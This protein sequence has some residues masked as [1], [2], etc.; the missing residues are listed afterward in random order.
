[1]SEL[2]KTI[3]ERIRARHKEISKR[4]APKMYLYIKISPKGLFY[5]GV[6]KDRKYKDKNIYTYRGSGKY[7]KLH[8]KSHNVTTKDIETII[9]HESYY[10]E[11]LVEL[12]KYYSRLF[13]V[14]K[15]DK[16]ANLK[17]EMY[18]G[19]DW[20]RTEKYKYHT[21][22]CPHCG[23]TGG[24]GNMKRYHFDNCSKIK[25]REI[26]YI[27]CPHCGIDCNKKSANHWHF[28]NCPVLKGI[29][30]A[31]NQIDLQ[32]GNIIGTYRNTREASKMTGITY[33][34]IQQVVNNK[35][36]IKKEKGREYKNSV[37]SAGGYKWEYITTK[38]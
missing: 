30:S 2:E 27:K 29:I 21:I 31:V 1:M 13:D 5:L 15:S 14:V 32:T 34:S 20:N 26:E 22:E 6:F 38:T 23:H 18:D 10:K 12:G 7:W 9:L 3:E 8:L 35:I 25:K 28:D 4:G 19:G 17:E 37:K 24:G 11:E 33:S 16:W 36:Y